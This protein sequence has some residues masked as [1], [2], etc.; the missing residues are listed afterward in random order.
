MFS[1]FGEY[2]YALLFAPFKKVRKSINQ[3]YL[4][5]KVIGKLF[6]NTKEDVFRVRS[7][8]MIATASELMLEQHGRDRGMIRLKGESAESFRNRLSMAFIIASQAG[9]N[10]AIRYVAKSFGYDNVSIETSA[11]SEKWAEVTV[12]FIGGDIV[13][14]DQDLLL[15]QLNQVKPASAL[16]TV[17]KEQRFTAQQYIGTAYIIGKVITIRQG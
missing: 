17:S 9:T 13:L 2:M 8:S 3:W 16:L 10:E 15:T 5:F 6:D 1:N 7:E 12:Q 4:F 11:D 14:D